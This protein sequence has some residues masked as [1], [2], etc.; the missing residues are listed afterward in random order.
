MFGAVLILASCGDSA[1]RVLGLQRTAPDEFAVVKRA[2]LSQPPDFKLRPPRPGAERPGVATPREQ[3]RQA[4]FRA[5]EA[6]A[7]SSTRRNE[8][9][10]TRAAPQEAVSQRSNGESAFLARA[11]ADNVEPDI[12]SKV[13][14]ESSI[15]AEANLN[16][17]QKLLNFDPDNEEVVDAAAESR[18]LR[19]NQALGRDATEGDTPL[20]DRKTNQLFK[21]F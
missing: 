3:A 4:I 10:S 9:P 20:I 5:D 2:P 11:G 12:R 18:R 21:I 15:L 13:D 8:G 19:E 6:D 16:F 17:V 7:A 1:K 14:R